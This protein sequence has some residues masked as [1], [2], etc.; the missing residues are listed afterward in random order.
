ML[1]VVRTQ[2]TKYE[3][4]DD[5]NRP[6]SS[7]FHFCL[8]YSS[9]FRFLICLPVCRVCGT[10]FNAIQASMYDVLMYSHGRKRS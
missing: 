6:F 5:K 3:Y 10:V 4:D 2:Y 8:F 1:F 7:T 9:V